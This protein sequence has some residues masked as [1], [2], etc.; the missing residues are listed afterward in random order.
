MRNTLRPSRIGLVIMMAFVAACASSGPNDTAAGPG[1]GAGAGAEG[2]TL[3]IHNTDGSGDPLTI[4]LL[5][6]AGEMTRLGTVAPYEY[7]TVTHPGGQGRFQL[8]GQRPA[9][10][11][12]TSPTFNVVSG[13]YTWDVALRRVER[14]R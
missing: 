8:R 7:L 2:V 4:F 6:E 5:P 9:G 1:A 11:T 10:S 13:T 12:V 3:R 14:S